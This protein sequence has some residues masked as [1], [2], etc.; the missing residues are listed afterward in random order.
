MNSPLYIPPDTEKTIDSVSQLIP[1]TK[2]TNS[3]V[4]LTVN[5][6]ASLVPANPFRIYLMIMNISDAS[7][8]LTLGQSTALTGQGMVLFGKRS[9]LEIN[10]NFLFREKIAAISEAPA[11]LSI[12]E[13]SL[14]TP[15][16]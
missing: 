11:I 14:D 2:A 4:L 10:P 3:K 13:C 7:V 12:V 8:Y 1:F 9:Y 15:A 16:K 5:V 6:S